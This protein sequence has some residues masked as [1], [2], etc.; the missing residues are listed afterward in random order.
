MINKRAVALG[1]A[2]VTLYRVMMV[3]VIAFIVLGV[4]SIF[5]VHYINI[6]ATEAV[7]LTRHVVDCFA[8]DGSLDLNLLRDNKGIEVF[9]YCHISGANLERFFVRVNISKVS[10]ENIFMFEQGDSGSL[11]V[12]KAIEVGIDKK[13]APGYYKGEYPVLLMED[14]NKVGDGKLIVESLVK[15]EK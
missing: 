6:R 1:S 8:P 12:R 13:Y 5:Y 9:D 2:V 10:G 11:W 3:I 4:S 15:Y 7:L 14:L